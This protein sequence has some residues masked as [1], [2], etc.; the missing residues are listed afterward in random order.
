MCLPDRADFVWSFLFFFFLFSSD[1]NCIRATISLTASLT[2][3]K[4]IID[5]SAFI[6]SAGPTVVIFLIAVVLTRRSISAVFCKSIWSLSAL[7]RYSYLPFVFDKPYSSY[8]T[9][10]LALTRHSLIGFFNANPTTIKTAAKPIAKMLLVV[11]KK[12]KPTAAAPNGNMKNKALSITI[13]V[14]FICFIP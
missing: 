3:S 6:G 14:Y 5:S 8:S 10:R 1:S 13:S 2:G 7:D 4:P 9:S 11:K 12:Y